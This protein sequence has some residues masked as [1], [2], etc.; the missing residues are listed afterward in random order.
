MEE[1]EKYALIYILQRIQPFPSAYELFEDED[2]SPETFCA[3][4]WKEV[5]GSRKIADF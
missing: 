1:K 5:Q 3:E 2:I 4:I